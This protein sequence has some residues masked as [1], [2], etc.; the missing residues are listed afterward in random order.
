MAP[1]GSG[2]RTI[3][4]TVATKIAKRRHPAGST[5]GGRGTANTIAP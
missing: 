2:S 1:E 4:L 3:P 5:P